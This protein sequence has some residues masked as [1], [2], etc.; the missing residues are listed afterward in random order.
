MKNEID[1]IIPINA[2]CQ[3][4]LI[5]AYDDNQNKNKK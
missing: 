4:Q 5:F 2:I 1:E 3:S